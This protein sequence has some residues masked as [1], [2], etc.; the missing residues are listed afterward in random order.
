M[1]WP[2]LLFL[3]SPKEETSFHE[4][5]GS[6]PIQ[7]ISFIELHFIKVKMQEFTSYI[8]STTQLWLE[9]MNQRADL[10]EDGAY[11]VGSEPQQTE[12]WRIP[13]E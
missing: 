7:F 6:F 5:S 2:L 11:K 3:L 8:S 12:L 13:R 4:Y 10:E 1:T 9:L